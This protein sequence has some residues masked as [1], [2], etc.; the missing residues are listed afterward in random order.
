MHGAISTISDLLK[1]ES[2]TN[3][4]TTIFAG[5]EKHIWDVTIHH[6]VSVGESIKL[7][8]AKSNRAPIHKLTT[9]YIPNPTIGVCKR[10]LI[11]G[12]KQLHTWFYIIIK[13]LIKNT[14]T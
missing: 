7:Y 12:G 2:N 4:L 1:F 13:V 11:S 8:L 14:Q 9:V 10:Y 6:E 5:I 3:M